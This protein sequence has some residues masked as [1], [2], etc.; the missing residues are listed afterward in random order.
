MTC[1]AMHFDLVD[2][3]L[4]A[5]IADANELARCLGFPFDLN[6]VPLLPA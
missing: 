1:M 3:R 2:L 5:H 6:L 4:M